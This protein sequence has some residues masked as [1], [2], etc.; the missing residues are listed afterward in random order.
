MSKPELVVQP[1]ARPTRKTE[2]SIIA[3]G[4]TAASVTPFLLFGLNRY[5]DGAIP[6]DVYEILPWV[7]AFL[8]WAI[9]GARA[10]FAKERSEFCPPKGER[11]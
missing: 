9:Q 3:G 7:T 10:Y 11:A 1:S 5:Y 4:V 6:E 8:V 2:Q